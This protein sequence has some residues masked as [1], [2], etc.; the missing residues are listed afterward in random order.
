MFW[1]KLSSYQKK[2]KNYHSTGNADQTL[3]RIGTK[4]S[5][6]PVI[7]ILAIVAYQQDAQ[8]GFYTFSIKYINMSRRTRLLQI[9]IAFGLFALFSLAE[10]SAA[11]PSTW[12][13]LDLEGNRHG[14]APSQTACDNITDGGT[15]GSDVQGCANPSFQA[16]QIVNLTFPTG[17]SGAIEY[18]W[19]MTTSNP[20]GAQPVSW[21]IIPGS[22]TPDYTPLPVTQTTYYMRCS[23]RADCTEYAGESNY[24]TVEID[25]CDNAT[26]GGT[27]EGDQ[28][29]CG[30]PYDPA[31]IRNTAGASGGSNGM[32]Y[33]WY[34]STTS[35]V[36]VLGSP[37]WVVA[38][39]A[40]TPYFD[41]PAVNEV[42]YFVRVANREFCTEPGAWSNVV[43][44][45]AYPIPTL[46][47]DTT[48]VTCFGESDGTATI[49]I[50]DAANPFTYQWLD[51]GSTDLTRTGMT[52][53]DYQFEIIDGNGCATIETVT[54]FSPAELT[55]G[56]TGNYDPC[57]FAN[58][59][60][61]EAE[62]NG[63]VEPYTYLWSTGA[64]TASISNVSAGIY[65]VDITDANGCTTSESI[66]VT[67]PSAL[68]A[69]VAFTDPI[70]YQANGTIDVTHAGGT[71]PFSYNWTPAVT[72]AASAT[73]L[74]GGV[75]TI[76][77][78]DANGCSTTVSATLDDT[79]PL[80]ITLDGDDV[81]CNGAANAEIRNTTTGGL[82]PY[83]YAWSNGATSQNLSNV[84]PGT[85]EVNV[86]DANGCTEVQS[87]TLAEPNALMAN[88]DVV[89][90]VCGED[91]GTLT[92]NISGGT[93]PY[94][95]NWGPVGQTDVMTLM[96]MPDGNYELNVTDA[97]GCVFQATT[98]VVDVPEMVLTTTKTDASCPGEDDGTASVV[99]TGGEA[100]Y[101]L[102]WSDAANQTDYTAVNLAAGTYTIEITDNRGC[103]RAET[104]TIDN[105]S[106]GPIVTSDVDELNCF[107]GT[108]ANIR[109]TVTGGVAPYTFMW[110][111]FVTTQN[112]SNLAAGTYEV[113]VT[114]AAGCESIQSFTFVDPVEIECTARPTS[115]F[116]NYFNVSRFGATDGS[117]TVDVTGG[118]MPYTYAWSNGVT[119]QGASGL[120]GGIVSVT[121]T[122]ANGCTCTHDTLLV[123]P[124]MISDF[125]FE[126]E[127]GDGIQDATETGL[128]DV[129]ITLSGSDFMGERINF[130][131][132]SD[133]NGAYRFDQL[134]MGNYF[135]IFQLPGTL[136]YLNSPVNQGSDP[137]LDSDMDPLTGSI[138]RQVTA[139]GLG[140]Y[141]TDAGFIPRE[142][143]I[144][145][146]DRAWYDENHDG[147]QNE[148]ETSIQGVTVRLIRSTDGF[149]V[150]ST[151]TDEEGNYFFNNVAPG[152][153]YV[154]ADESTSS[155]AST[156]IFTDA[157]QGTDENLDSDFDPITK[158][159]ADIIVT[160]ASL[161]IDN[162]D[163]GLHENCGEVDQ[164][165][166]ITGTES[167]CHGAI[168]LPVT[169]TTVPSGAT[170][171]QWIRSSSPVYA[172]PNDPN[173]T[174]INGA[175]GLTYQPSSLVATVNYI[176]LAR[177]AGCVDYTGA[178][179]VVTKTVIPLPVAK[180]NS[181][182][183]TFCLSTSIDLTADSL[184]PAV[185]EWDFGTDATPS[186]ATG[187]AISNVSFVNAGPR[188][189]Y[190][191]V[192]SPNGC[193]GRDSLQINTLNC[194]GPGVIGQT[195]GLS[196]AGTNTVTWE[197][198]SLLEGS[199]FD[200]E[201]MLENDEYEV[202]TSV[203]AK[204]LAA[205]FDY[206]YEDKFAPTGDVSYR[207]VHR[208]PT[209]DDG[210]SAEVRL[211]VEQ[212]A[213][214]AK[215]YPNPVGNLLTV[216]LA[217]AEVGN[218]AYEIINSYGTVVLAGTYQSGRH[219]M[220]TSNLPAGTYYLRAIAQDGTIEVRAL[221]KH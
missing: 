89:Q 65:S 82:A 20:A 187:S 29:A 159:S 161:D 91:G 77:I 168:P 110:D 137:T 78:I 130:S 23:R 72:T 212:M 140:D 83:T 218:V 221:V 108:G 131:T 18:L 132:T 179:N 153:Y 148:F 134:P 88:I 100:P 1:R 105:Q 135:L 63:G 167:V 27:I 50:I 68:T 177:V 95:F 139:H 75:Y 57:A 92:A 206:T 143:V 194:F 126:D 176:R 122:D 41:P 163:M 151:V 85:Y 181:S 183:T 160:S 15:I 185:F 87:I 4:F 211:S 197:A 42:T 142:S 204:G 69:S 58:D 38:S 213:L 101:A 47:A 43:T 136:D 9:A 207:I 158:R 44:I 76:E 21:S 138:N 12:S 144:V 73:G 200:V 14:F 70:C 180:I 188:F 219:E 53:G 80:T 24:V 203:N 116:L 94:T 214:M 191:S 129:S 205:W 17:G 192:T 40:T 86:T 6:S 64:T 209:S 5:A 149:L 156:F 51:N 113:T 99:V 121:V 115:N 22:T 169:S 182:A 67:P 10:S 154:E 175:R 186:T 62:V 71:A 165:G 55:V 162:I 102:Q 45:S 104:V 184:S 195:S 61:L 210:R 190:L 46:K 52:A 166:E 170:E 37:D 2:G 33:T 30:I 74:T 28:T 66:A 3:F 164:A 172:G 145:I 114:D 34:S 48:A 123:E 111:D 36:Y 59:A 109:L 120:S 171:Y 25:C 216:E 39:S 8:S 106:T 56:I 35:N 32:R 193:V 189:I 60:V 215:I 81:T 54:I 127:D 26:D 217:T 107:G 79:S 98:T 133:A 220:D 178:S 103:V 90:P 112:R 150:N 147:I 152:T 198:I 173:W 155:I 31:L 119:E 11:T 97:S 196:Q 16:P 128:A 84:G 96:N 7:I 201:R 19:M 174:E 208:A 125:V 118:S 199:Y 93:P 202:I 157:L 49:T 117:A 146:S 124:S 141:D 13:Y